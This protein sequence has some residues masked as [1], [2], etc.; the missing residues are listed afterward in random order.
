M[1]LSAGI[2]LVRRE[3][4]TWK[5]LFLRAFRNWDFPKGV[6]ESGEQPLDTAK[7]E[8]AEET[9]IS[10][11]HFRWGYIYRETEPYSGGSKIA[12]YYLAET[13]SS[14]VVFSVNPEIGKP[15]HHEYRWLPYEEIKKLAPERL[16][17]IVEWANAVV[18]GSDR[19]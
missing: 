8:V 3:E 14:S 19:G 9:G 11:L 17:G 10:D 18:Q 2:V 7:R 12:R 5:Y 13:R 1:N 4:G 15:E 6:V 16:K